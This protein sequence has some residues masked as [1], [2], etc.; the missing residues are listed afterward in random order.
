MSP[1]SMPLDQTL[2]QINGIIKDAVIPLEPQLLDSKTTFADILPRLEELRVATKAAG[3][4]APFL[5][6]A[7]G[8]MG[9]SL[10]EYAQIS[11]ALG[12]SPLGHYIFNCQV[13]DVGNMELLMAYGTPSQ[14]ETYLAP[15][16]KG[17]I[18]SCF[19]MTE[20]DFPGS[21]PTWMGATAQEDGDYFINGR[22]WF[23]SSADGA[24]F[25]IVMAVT[26]PDAARKNGPACSLCPWIIRA[27]NWSATFRLWV[28]RGTTTAHTPK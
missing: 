20:P 14:K 13:P 27:L 15:L 7:E 18:R 17:R 9:F 16:I 19:S 10:I 11:E 28:I 25:A 2:T 1:S 21:N 12:R 8:G 26:N 24:S 3:L 23:T 6:Q 22:K 4:W 5:S